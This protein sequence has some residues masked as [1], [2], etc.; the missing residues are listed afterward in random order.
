MHVLGI[1][2]DKIN[3][4]NICRIGICMRQLGWFKK[5]TGHDKNKYYMR[6]NLDINQMNDAVKE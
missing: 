6:P 3:H 1:Q 5:T 2:K 4:A